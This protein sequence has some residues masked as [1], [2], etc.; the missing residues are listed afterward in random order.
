MTEPIERCDLFA[1]A[2]SKAT[3]MP[4]ER[5]AMLDGIAK[6]TAV[7]PGT[8]ASIDVAPRFMPHGSTCEA[9]DGRGSDFGLCHAAGYGFAVHEGRDRVVCRFHFDRYQG[10]RIRGVCS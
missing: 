6:A 9:N 4:A 10:R 7:P 3:A 8:M 2:M 1:S 5:Q